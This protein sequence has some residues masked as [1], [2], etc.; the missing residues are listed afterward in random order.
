MSI[1]YTGVGLV[2]V[3]LGCLQVVLDKGQEEDWLSSHFI[4]VLSV[5][6]AVALVSFVVWE[7][8]QTHPILDVRLF[9][10]RSFA[11]TGLMM[12]AMGFGLYGSTV[13]LPLYTQQI[14]GYSAQTA[15]MVISPG[16]IAVIVVMPFLGFLITKVQIRWHRSLVIM[17]AVHFLSHPSF[18]ILPYLAPRR[19]YVL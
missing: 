1:D 12:F 8:R 4:V 16:G 2:L 18:Q 6:A 7:W 19:P 5:I 17:A 14:L 10:K 13:L 15:G 9:A 3:G 11:I